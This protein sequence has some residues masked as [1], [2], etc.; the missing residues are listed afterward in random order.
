MA[1][2]TEALLKAGFVETVFHCAACGAS[3]TS[4]SR[5]AALLDRRCLDCGEPV[6]TTVLGRFS[7]PSSAD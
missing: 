3:G 6:V 4:L 7:R 2:V 5:P 1:E